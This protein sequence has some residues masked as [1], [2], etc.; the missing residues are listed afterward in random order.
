MIEL[1]L[2]RL[3]ITGILSVVLAIG[4]LGQFA[5]YKTK[6]AI[7][8]NKVQNQI[9]QIRELASQRDDL[10]NKNRAFARVISSQN[11]SIENMLKLSDTQRR[12]LEDAKAETTKIQDS[13]N[14]YLAHLNQSIGQ[15]DRWE[16]LANTYGD[17]T[18]EWGKSDTLPSEVP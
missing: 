3:G 16:I 4:M 2:S 12:R 1:I 7:L 18:K 11:E 6:N 9:T 15:G 14:K 13:W 10:L 5:Y 17:A 8:E